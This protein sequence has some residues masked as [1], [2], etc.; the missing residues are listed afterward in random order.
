MKR[1]V[2]WKVPITGLV[3]LNLSVLFNFDKINLR[4]IVSDGR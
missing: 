2:V 4:K 1:L 3:G